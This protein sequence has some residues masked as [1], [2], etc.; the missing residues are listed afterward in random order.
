MGGTAA[1]FDLDLFAGR[2]VLLTGDTGFKGSWLSLWLHELGAKVTGY[3]LP[4][5]T[6]PSNFEVA[7]AE[8]LLER[9]YNADVR[10]RSALLAALSASDP[11]VV[12]HLAART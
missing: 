11:D 7:S 3:A 1:G 4:P 12:L 8:E 10:D 5:P 6:Q 9:R 2:R